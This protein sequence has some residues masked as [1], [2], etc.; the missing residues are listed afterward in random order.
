MVWALFAGKFE[1][2]GQKKRSSKRVGTFSGVYFQGNMKEKFQKKWSSKRGD[3]FFRG[4]FSGKHEGK[5]FRKGFKK[6]G[7]S[8][9]WPMVK[10]WC[11]VRMVYGRQGMVYGQDGCLLYTSP[12]PRD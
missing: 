11:M 6:D 10:G 8:S 2:K 1:K 12:S 4:V 9:G 3:L 7:L 5:G